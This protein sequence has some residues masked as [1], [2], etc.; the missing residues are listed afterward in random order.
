[1]TGYYDAVLGLIPILFAGI[2]GVLLLA[3]LALVVSIAIGALA[4][5]GLIGHA[6]FVRAPTDAPE[7]TAPSTGPVGAD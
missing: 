1:M 2:T 6:M 5:G 3:G 4:A 7:T